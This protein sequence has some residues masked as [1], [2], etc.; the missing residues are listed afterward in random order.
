MCRRVAV[1]DS[2]TLVYST[3]ASSSQCSSHLSTIKPPMN[4]RDETFDIQRLGNTEI[5]G[6]VREVP[7][8]SHILTHVAIDSPLG[9][10]K[11]YAVPF[12][13]PSPPSKSRLVRGLTELPDSK[14]RRL[15]LHQFFGNDEGDSDQNSSHLTETFSPPVHS[16]HCTAWRSERSLYRRRKHLINLMR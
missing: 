12:R 7:V 8:D 16:L 14:G 5:R 6:S 9:Q 13:I 15:R 2:Q 1:R 11:E 10:K 3:A 4:C